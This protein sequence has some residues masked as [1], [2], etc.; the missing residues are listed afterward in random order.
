MADCFYHTGRPSVTRCKQCGRP[1]CGECKIVAP[2]GVFCSEKCKDSFG[3]FAERAEEIEAKKGKTSGVNAVVK[4]V[5][6][7]IFLLVLFYILRRF[8]FTG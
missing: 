7:L 5:I 8:F 3:V 2:G 1:L 6:L 4:L